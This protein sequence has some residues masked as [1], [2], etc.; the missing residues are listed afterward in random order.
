M[1]RSVLAMTMA[2][3]L[4]AFAQSAPAEDGP[5]TL[6]EHGRVRQAATLSESRLKS[7]PK[8]VE[9]LRVLATIRAIEKKWDEA[10]DLAEKAVAAAPNDADAHYAAAQVAGM[11]AQAASVLKKPGLA[12]R[13]RKETEKALA[14]DP[15]HENVLEG[16][17]AF[18]REAPGIVGGDRKKGAEF[19]ERLMKVDPTRGWLQKAD[20]AFDDKD[21][22]TAESCLRNAVMVK[23]EPRAKMAL[24][25]YLI[26]PWRNPDEA[27]KLAREAVA[28]EPWRAGGWTVIAV[29]EALRKQWSEMDATLAKAEAA[30]PGNFGP[31]Y[32]VA[33]VLI[34]EK[35][36]GARAEALL[37]RYLTVQPEI[38]GPS[39]AG[40][41]WRLGQALE[42]QGKPSEAI[43]EFQTAAKLDP[44]LDGPKKDLK[45]LKG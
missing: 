22:V 21:S 15:N 19:A 40:A 23:G 9:S 16:M 13:F 33:R 4:A 36:D 26:Q 31:H 34:T 28:A 27:E 37:R 25:S 42:M 29:R 45:R 39:H 2:L 18:H 14:I 3:P 44:K 1:R 12:G 10:G 43:A 24:A 35:L 32:Q 11:Q 8:D 7:N 41:H 5:Q 30:I 6:M 20:N 17:I 38:G